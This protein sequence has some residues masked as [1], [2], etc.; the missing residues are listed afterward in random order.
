[1]RLTLG[2]LAF[3]ATTGVLGHGAVQAQIDAATA[4]IARAPSDA[5]LYLRRGELH[6]VHEDWD[7][8]LADFDRAATLAP[9]DDTIDFLRGRTLEQAGRAAPARIALDRYLAQ[10]PDHADA[11]LARARALR[12]LGEYPAAASDFT[13]A[14]DLI[15]RPDPDV[16][17]ERAHVEIARGDADGALAGIDAGIAGVGSIASLQSFAIEIELQRGRVDEALARLER[18][19]VQSPRKE[20]WLARRGD[21]LAGAGREPEARAAYAAAL[22]AIEAL[23]RSARRTAAMVSLEKHVRAALATP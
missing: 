5:R 4:A 16:F 10:H 1:L 22:A 11:L 2:A 7:G 3:A 9:G 21:I 20:S 19:A 14:I 15:A 8:A 17:L 6:R 18:V 23:P 12:A 13:R